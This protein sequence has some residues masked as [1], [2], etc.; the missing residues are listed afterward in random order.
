M[1][2]GFEQTVKIN[3]R[4]RM[5]AKHDYVNDEEAKEIGVTSYQQDI[6][7][8]FDR[9]ERLIGPDYA[10]PTDEEEWCEFWEEVWSEHG[11]LSELLCDH[12]EG[13]AETWEDRAE[14][15]Q[16]FIAMLTPKPM[17]VAP[18]AKKAKTTSQ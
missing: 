15:G 12:V 17:S 5:L 13:V 18:K 11:S 3:G 2:A 16:A 14:A 10:M 6:A 9:L 7:E 4:M 8:A 1:K